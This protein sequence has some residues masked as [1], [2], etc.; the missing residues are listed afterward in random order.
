MSLSYCTFQKQSLPCVRAYVKT[1]TLAHSLQ[2]AHQN[3][4]EFKPYIYANAHDWKYIIII[5]K[6]HIGFLRVDFYLC[7]LRC[8]LLNYTRICAH[9]F[10]ESILRYI[11]LLKC[12]LYLIEK[13]SQLYARCMRVKYFL[14]KIII[15]KNLNKLKHIFRLGRRD[16][17]STTARNGLKPKNITLHIY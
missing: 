6:C 10:V 15:L 7:A 4:L 3:T 17:A 9:N 11:S 13:A 8:N 14:M 2:L 5:I 16:E 12:K 1:T